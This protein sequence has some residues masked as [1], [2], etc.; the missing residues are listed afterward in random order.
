[1]PH[2][3]EKHVER[4]LKGKRSGKNIGS[5]NMPHHLLPYEKKKFELAIKKRVLIVDSRDRVNLRNVWEKYCQSKNWPHV[6]IVHYKGEGQLFVDDDNIINGEL[7]A[8]K[9]LAKSIV[10]KHHRV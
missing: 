10:F 9:E 4:L 7:K 5:R 3:K 2:F 8:I 1:M 6:L